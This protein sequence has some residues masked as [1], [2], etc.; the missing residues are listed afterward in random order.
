MNILKQ[1]EHALI[2]QRAM[3]RVRAELSTYSERELTTDLRLN[4]SDISWFAAKAGQ[5]AGR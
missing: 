5:R 1:I 2:R 4:R 3:R